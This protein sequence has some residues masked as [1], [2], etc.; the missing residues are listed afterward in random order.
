M[1]EPSISLL[2]KLGSI[3]VHAQELLSDNGHHFDR[4]ALESLMADAEVKEW[5]SAMNSAAMLPVKRRRT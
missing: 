2:C 4:V 1:L 5:L 3:A